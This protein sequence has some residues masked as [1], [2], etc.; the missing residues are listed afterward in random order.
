MKAIGIYA[1]VGIATILL[2]LFTSNQRQDAL[3]HTLELQS[4]QLEVRRDENYQLNIIATEQSDALVQKDSIIKKQENAITK[5]IARL[6]ESRKTI[7]K[8]DKEIK[9]TRDKMQK[10]AEVIKQVE[11]KKTGEPQKKEK[12]VRE[13]K[14]SEQQDE[15][16]PEKGEAVEV[17]EPEKEP[18]KQEEA[19][20]EPKP[21]PK[22]EPVEEPKVEEKPEPKPVEPPEEPK[23]EEPE[24]EEEP[25]VA[26][27]P[28]EPKG[29]TFT[30]EATAYIAFCDTGCTGVTATG[31]DVKNTIL[32]E[33]IRIIAVDPNVIPLHT[34]VTVTL[35][36]G[37]S[38]PAIAL[39]TGGAIQGNRV[40]LLVAT[41][42]E[43][44]AFG[45]QA[46]QITLP[47]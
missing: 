14:T 41:H 19:K 5:Y 45:R 4:E 42:E 36:N 7:T 11:I 9:A 17:Q 38:F 32:Y 1:L 28:V 29:N 10:Q 37:N 18:E 30:V 34:I 13:E 22:P 6:Q 2:V 16:E 3:E 35:P 47:N 33:G 12:A 26:T 31:Y 43:A 15:S 25:P 27:K 24:K 44:I 46:L 40:D 8:K 23:V 39:D 21:E 20:E